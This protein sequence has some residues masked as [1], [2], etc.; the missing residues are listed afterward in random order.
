MTLYRVREESHDGG[1]QFNLISSAELD[2]AKFAR[3]EANKP[4]CA[5]TPQVEVY[6]VNEDCCVRKIEVSVKLYDEPGMPKLVC[7]ACGG[8]VKMH[9][10]VEYEML[11]P[12]KDE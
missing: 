7:P 6:C 10:F 9:G 3:I 8:P 1:F 5:V 11:L 2:S 12:V 4:K